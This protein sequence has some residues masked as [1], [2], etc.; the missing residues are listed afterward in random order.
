M[1]GVV[2]ATGL[3]IAAML[4]SFAAGVGLTY[5]VWGQQPE[6]VV[7]YSKG[8]VRFAPNLGKPNEVITFSDVRKVTYREHYVEVECVLAVAGGE[9]HTAVFVVPKER[10]LYVGTE[11]I[12][13]DPD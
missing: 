7:T 4:L 5:L 8:Y 9:K 1:R 12:P 3:V 10:L 6:R 13:G 2:A 11:K